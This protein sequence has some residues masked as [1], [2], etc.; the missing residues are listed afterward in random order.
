MKILFPIGS[1]FP[2]QSGGPS[3]TIYWHARALKKNGVIRPI[4]ITTNKDINDS[5]LKLD[6]LLITEAGEVTYL[7]TKNYS[8]PFKLIVKSIGE[9]KRVDIIHLT[10]LFFIPSIFIAIAARFYNKKVVWSVRGELENGALGYK[11]IIKLKYLSLLRNIT[12]KNTIFHATSKSEEDNVKRNFPKADIITLPNFISLPKLVNIEVRKQFLF[13]GRIHPIKNI[14]GI[15]KSVASSKEFKKNDFKLVIAGGG[16]QNYLNKLKDL[17]RKLNLKDNVKFI[18]H[19]EKEEK[20]KILA[21][22]YCLILASHSENFGNVV[23]E[24]LAQKTPVIATEGTPWEIL[25]KSKAGIWIRNEETILTECIDD[26][27]QK[28]NRDYLKMR[29]NAYKLVKDKYDVDANVDKWENV[30][31]KSKKK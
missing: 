6:E 20:Q 7:K 4:V 17:V 14:D 9:I 13:L 16:E 29:D 11:S 31:L 5:N 15:I 3:N 2:A 22:S 12:K 1:F 24:A 21:E 23:V 27:I 25:N 8:L 28:E 18:G 26:L 10:S 30:Y 19:I